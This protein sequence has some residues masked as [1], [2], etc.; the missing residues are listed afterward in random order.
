MTG[1]EKYAESG[2][3]TTKDLSK[4]LKVTERTIYI[5]VKSG[6]IVE[7]IKISNG[8]N[9]WL[10]KEIDKWMEEKQKWSSNQT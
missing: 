5:W 2:F 6:T 3:L 10:R 1:G 7:P 8:R 9:L 4:L